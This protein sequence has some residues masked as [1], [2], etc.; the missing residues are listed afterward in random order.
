MRSFLLNPSTRLRLF[1]LSLVLVLFLGAT[2]VASAQTPSSTPSE[3]LVP[4]RVLSSVEAVYPLEALASR[5]EGVTVLTVT[6]A[7]NGKVSDVQVAQ[8]AGEAFDHAALEA[9]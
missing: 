5:Q 8:S 9:A 1:P 2:G 3:A 6:I 7:A 4:P